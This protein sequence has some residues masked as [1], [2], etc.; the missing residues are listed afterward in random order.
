VACAWAPKAAPPS[1]RAASAIITFLR[2]LF[3][4]FPLS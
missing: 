1:D 4:V 2:T 3:M